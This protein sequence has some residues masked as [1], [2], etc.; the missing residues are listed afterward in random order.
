MDFPTSRTHAQLRQVE[1]LLLQDPNSSLLQNLK[2]QLIQ[3]MT[4]VETLRALKPTGNGGEELQSGGWTT[5]ADANIV[6]PVSNNNNNSN[7]N[8]SF[9]DPFASSTSSTKS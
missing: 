6:V 1:E 2:T 3:G 7:N 8:F 5:V 4:W 9:Y